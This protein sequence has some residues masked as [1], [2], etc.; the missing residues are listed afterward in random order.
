MS[1]TEIIFKMTIQDLK[2]EVGNLDKAEQADLVHYLV[3][4]IANDK[5]Q[6]SEALKKELNKREKAYRDGTSVGRPARE[7]IQEFLS[8]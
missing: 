6:L 8:K 2:K 5:F 7:V 1:K 3:E 4:L